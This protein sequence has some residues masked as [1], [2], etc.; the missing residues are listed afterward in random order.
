MEPNTHENEQGSRSMETVLNEMERA[1]VEIEK[2]GK[3]RNAALASFLGGGLFA[4]GIG[5]FELSEAFEIA[6]MVRIATTVL[7]L[8]WFVQANRHEI[9]GG[10]LLKGRKAVGPVHDY[11]PFAWLFWRK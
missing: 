1:G 9:T 5:W 4:G 3:K 8:V 10:R 7:A 2:A 6:S 11:G